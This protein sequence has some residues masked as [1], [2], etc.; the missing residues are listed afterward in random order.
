MI[1]LLR[2][3]QQR[4]RRKPRDNGVKTKVEKTLIQSAVNATQFK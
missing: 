4:T 3:G 2:A 1:L